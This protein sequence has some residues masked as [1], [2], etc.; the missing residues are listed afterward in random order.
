MPG[1]ND[2]PKNNQLVVRQSFDI[3]GNKLERGLFINFT[4]LRLISITC[5][6]MVEKTPTVINQATVIKSD[7][8][9]HLIPVV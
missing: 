9:N 5:F 8:E 3:S 6:I 7:G 4:T 1:L 2:Y